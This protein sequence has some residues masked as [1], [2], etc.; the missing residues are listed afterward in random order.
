MFRSFSE[1]RLLCL[2]LPLLLNFIPA[3]CQSVH[4][5]PTDPL[6]FAQPSSSVLSAGDEVALF[7]HDFPLSFKIHKDE[8]DPSRLLNVQLPGDFHHFKQFIARVTDISNVYEN[9]LRDANRTFLASPSDN[10]VINI[11]GLNPGHQYSIAILGRK[12]DESTLIKEE[13]VVMDPI[14]LD[15]NTSSTIRV[16]YHNVTIRVSKPER[17]LQDTFRVEYIQLD[18]LRRYPILDVHDIQEQREVELYLGNLNPGRDYSVTVTSIKNDL[19]SVPWK[20][21]ITT[22]P[23]KP[24]NLSVSEVN[25]MCV[26]LFWTLPPES[27]AD[28]FKIAYGVLNAEENMRK[29][30]VPYSNRQVDLC[31][32]VLPGQSLLFAVVAEKSHEISDP[33]TISYT[34]R[35]LPP[36]DLK[37]VADFSKAKFRVELELPSEKAS[38]VDKCLITVVS[39]QLEK[40]EHRVPAVPVE[41]ARP[42]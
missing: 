40:M 36:S 16:T 22:K 20:G 4:V 17:A 35:P 29:L 28:R 7:S 14:P 42:T 13:S 38:K 9:R 18:P 21:V 10:A 2:L 37:V 26:S 19:P 1:D 34:V 15:F 24:V 32:G 27:G 41:E 25:A 39:E 5:A 3:D 30:E 31:D 11:H 8:S 6:P 12:D 33:S 23:F